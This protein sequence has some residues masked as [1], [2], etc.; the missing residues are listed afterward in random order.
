MVEDER[1]GRGPL[2]GL[3]AG[4]E[5]AAGEEIAF[6]AATDAPFLHPRFVA[7]VCAAAAA[8]GVDAA[9]P[10]LGGHRQPLLAAYRT[11]LLPLLAE[12]VAADRMK[13][14]FLFERCAVR[15]LDALPHPESA[16]NLNAPRGL[17]A[18]AGR[19]AAARPRAL[20][21]GAAA[22]GRRR[23]RGDARGGRGGASA[24]RSTAT[25]PPP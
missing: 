9:V 4:L 23:A 25:W 5:A 12:L 3:L 1:E 13:S 6:V 24:W 17:R 15:W 21:R 2:Q 18:G 10:H 22:P 11:A 14:A 20:L 7:A 19:A 8:P 16:R